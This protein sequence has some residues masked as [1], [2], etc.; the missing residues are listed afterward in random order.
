MRNKQIPVYLAPV[1]ICALAKVQSLIRPLRALLRREN[2]S[3]KASRALYLAVRISK[4]LGVLEPCLALP[5]ERRDHVRLGVSLDQLRILWALGFCRDAAGK[6]LRSDDGYLMCAPSKF[7]VADPSFSFRVG[8]SAAASLDA[9]KESIA[10]AYR[11]TPRVSGRVPLGEDRLLTEKE[12]GESRVRG[13]TAAD[14][15]NGVVTRAL[16]AAAVGGVAGPIAMAAAGPAALAGFAAPVVAGLA[17]TGAVVA[18]ELFRSAGEAVAGHYKARTRNYHQAALAGVGVGVLSSALTG[19]P[20]AAMV[21]PG[22]AALGYAQPYVGKYLAGLKTRVDDYRSSFEEGRLPV[23]ES[24]PKVRSVM[25]G[26]EEILRNRAR[27]ASLSELGASITE[28]NP[29]GDGISGRA[30]TDDSAWIV[31]KRGLARFGEK[32]SRYSKTE[33]DPELARKISVQKQEYHKIVHAFERYMEEWE[34]SSASFFGGDDWAK[35]AM[36]FEKL[37]ASPSGEAKS[38][39]QVIRDFQDVPGDTLYSDRASVE[40]IMEEF[41]AKRSGEAKGC[42][43]LTVGEVWVKGKAYNRKILHDA[44]LIRAQALNRVMRNAIGHA[45]EKESGGGTS[46]GLSRHATERDRDK[47]EKL[48]RELN[49]AGISTRE[50]DDINDN[51]SRRY[52]ERMESVLVTPPRNHERRRDGD[53]SKPSHPESA[54]MRKKRAVHRFMIAANDFVTTK[55]ESIFQQVMRVK[56]AGDVPG[57]GSELQ[58]MRVSSTDVNEKPFES[59]DRKLVAVAADAIRVLGEH[60]VGYIG[61]ADGSKKIMIERL[62]TTRALHKM[63]LALYERFSAVLA[64]RGDALEEMRRLH[65]QSRWV[66]SHISRLANG[67]GGILLSSAD[68]ARDEN[69]TRLSIHASQRLQETKERA[70]DDLAASAR[71]PDR[72]PTR[73]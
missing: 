69:L 66:E 22:A 9:H 60:E 23:N 57:I 42:V 48:G 31:E 71:F 8:G 40:R 30:D 3:M 47:L 17:G 58:I 16:I 10:N 35:F 73:W 46:R 27:V 21:A 29:L 26:R 55:A 63:A 67:R 53:A 36:E 44:K 64:M 7:S 49:D 56:V 32:M 1:D 39:L 25:A 18:P 4:I 5:A 33:G 13:Q 34:R 50:L 14:K 24:H 12:V 68:I 20:V 65:E 11:R 38:A 61:D 6:P 72:P 54:G 45:E 62:L 70:A 2:P 19:S 15:E 37:Q 43:E 51:A 28:I 41:V 59:R 52:V